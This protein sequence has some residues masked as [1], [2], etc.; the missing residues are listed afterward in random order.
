MSHI[1]YVIC[2]LYNHQ[3]PTKL[4]SRSTSTLFAMYGCFAYGATTAT[5]KAL[6]LK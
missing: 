3:R 4:K 1:V 6:N 5:P 2:Y